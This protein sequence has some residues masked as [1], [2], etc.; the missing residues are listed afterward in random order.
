MNHVF[1]PIKSYI[2]V[3]NMHTIIVVALSCAATA[4]CIHFDVRID[5][6]TGIIG[7][8]I[9]FPIVFSI[10]AAY[11]RREDALKYFASLKAHAASLYY[12]HRD[13]IPENDQQ[14][15]RRMKDIFD[16]LLHSVHYY[17]TGSEND[18]EKLQKVYGQFSHLSQ[19]MEVLRTAGVSGSEISRGNQYLR[20]IMIEFERMRNIHLYRT[21]KTLRAYSQV[22]LNIFPILYAPY[23]AYVSDESM[24]VSGYIV[25]VFYSLVLV[26]LDNIQEDLENPYDGF[27]ADDLHLDVAENYDK[28]LT[29]TVQ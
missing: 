23:F 5:L 10:N 19:S 3:V 2:S 28:I 17:F 6:P 1:G 15:P 25:A 4:L 24:W 29:N 11:R 21:P 27:G 20:A 26:S 13:W 16:N 7:L 18:N 8:A 22:F 12:A 9:V 14:H